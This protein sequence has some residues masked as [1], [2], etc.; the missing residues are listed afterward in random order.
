MTKLKGILFFRDTDAI[1]NAYT[2]SKDNVVVMLGKVVVAV[3][4]PL[5]LKLSGVG[6]YLW[7]VGDKLQVWKDVSSCWNAV[8]SV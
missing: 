4:E 7:V 3:K 1:I 6:K 8:L 5:R 2:Y